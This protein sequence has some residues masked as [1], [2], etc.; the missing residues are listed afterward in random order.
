MGKI[1]SIIIP[2]FNAEKWIGACIESAI[3]QTWPYKEVIVV[4]DG[5]KDST[6]KI[7]R[8]FASTMVHVVTQ[9]NRGASS[10]RNLGLS[11]AKGEYI[12]WLDADDLLDPAKVERQMEVAG[13]GQ[14]STILLSGAWGKFISWPEKAVF[15]PDLLWE[16]LSPL[17]WLLRKIEHNLWMPP[18]VFITSRKLI[19]TA[20]CWNETM[21]LD[22]DGE[23]FSRIISQASKI[24]FISEARSFKRSTFG[25]SH[26][27]NLSNSKLNSLWYSI[28]SIIR[29]VRS[30]NDDSQTRK[31]CL[32]FLNRLA[33]YFYPQRV[34]IIAQMQQLA[35]ELGG[36]IEKPALRKKYRWIQKFFG[37]ET[38]KKAQFTLPV[39]RQ[40]THMA[41]GKLT[42]FFKMV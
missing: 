13:P 25:L 10:A 32:I 1:V 21:S 37:W 31:V 11:I 27:V 30:I 17:E 20:G 12:Q 24:Q 34:D 16:D 28:S 40:F 15:S 42:K 36:L 8:S 41:A 3:T 26:D 33:I 39:V 6:L 29:R 7:A 18:M 23:Y 22:D 2:A 35:I 4:D 14:N 38:A 19:E 9:D 5:S